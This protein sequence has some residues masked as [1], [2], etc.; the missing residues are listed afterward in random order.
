MLTEKLEA[1]LELRGITAETASKLGWSATERGDAW[2]EIPYTRSGVIVNKKYRTLEGEKKFSQSKGGERCL[3]NVDV[4]GELGTYP[5]VLTE[6]EMDCAIALQCGHL[7]VSVP[8][9]APSTS[10]EGFDGKKYDYLSDIPSDCIVILCTDADEPGRALLHDLSIRIGKERCKWVK[11]PIGCKDLNETFMKYGAKGVDL[12]IQRAQN[13][14]IDGIFRMSELPPIPKLEAYPCPVNGL[15]ET[16]KFRGGDFTV[17]S[18]IPSHGKTTFVNEVAVGM[19]KQYGWPVAVASFE[20]NPKSDHLKALR[21]LYHE[22]PA[23]LQTEPQRDEADAWIDQNFTFI[24][25]SIDDD[26]TLE[27]CMERCRAAIVQNGCKLIIIDPWNEMDHIYPQ[28]MSLTQYT[29]FAIKQFK[30]LARKYLIHLIVVAHPAKMQ[31]LKDGTYPIPTLYDISDSAAWYNKADI[32]I[33]VHKEDEGTTLIKTAKIRYK[34]TIGHQ[35]EVK[36]KFD[37]Y[38][39]RYT[40]ID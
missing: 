12:T 37:D 32:G 3:Y 19:A 14:K 26:V 6:G 38:R 35:D 18:G 10:I 8:D 36:L 20:Q 30:K 33:M 27:W 29:G 39:Y 40:K 28:G 22:R 16:I 13:I 23:H 24:V 31:K 7:A 9:G 11:Y 1:L 5:L 25:P 4:I 2:I 15:E 21:T 34:G 17:I